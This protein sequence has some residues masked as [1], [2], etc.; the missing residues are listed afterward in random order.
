MR[1][2]L[3]GF[4]VVLALMNSSYADRRGKDS[5]NE[6]QETRNEKRSSAAPIKVIAFGG[7]STIPLRVAQTRGLFTKRGL[8]VTIEITPNS[9]QLRQ[10]LAKGTYDVAHAAVDNAVSMKDREGA[11]VVIILGGDD[12]MNELVAQP[13]VAD[14]R[15]LRGRTLIVDAPTT[16][17]ALQMKRILLSNGLTAGRDYAVEAIGGTPQRLEAMRANRT[18]AATMLNPPF[19]IQ[20]QQHGFKSLGFARDL[21]G[22]YQ[23]TGAFVRPSWGTAHRDV[24]VK[25]IAAYVEGLRWFVA[26][27]NRSAAIELLAESLEMPAD[28][29]AETYE[30]AVTGKG[31]ASDAQV[32]TE[33]FRNVLKL[34]AELEPDGQQARSPDRYLD[35]SYHRAALAMLDSGAK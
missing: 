11:D 20:A 32:D 3:A 26:P 8:T 30:R 1:H 34:R 29:A 2:L 12:S 28:V 31:F 16:A 10:G 18:Y 17:Y 24:L 7:V 22:R 35:L 27:Q 33:G 21:L 15:D 4:L 14:I 23:G 25:Y 6:K 5:I 9:N 13:E 19:S